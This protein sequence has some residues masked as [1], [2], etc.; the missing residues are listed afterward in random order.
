[1]VQVVVD[2]TIVAGSTCTV[3]DSTKPSVRDAI[4]LRDRRKRA[5]YEQAASRQNTT[6]LPICSTP[7]GTFNSGTVTL[8]A[9]IAASSDV[10]GYSAW[11]AARDLRRVVLSA[12]A[13]SLC[14]AE[15]KICTIVQPGDARLAREI[16]S[17]AAVAEATPQSGEAQRE[18]QV[19]EE[20]EDLEFL[21]S[22]SQRT[23]NANAVSFVPTMTV[24]AGECAMGGASHVQ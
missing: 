9:M 14:N 2:V 16:A 11:D 12:N 22:A 18:Q 1:M 15:R 13:Q 6:L 19:D 10:P 8:C 24:S 3:A 5:L 7:N 20:E 23:L 4:D 21:R 17:A